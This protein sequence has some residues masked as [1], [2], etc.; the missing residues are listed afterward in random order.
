MKKD[1]PLIAAYGLTPEQPP[2][3]EAEAIGEVK[4]D[5]PAWVNLYADHP[6]TNSW[7]HQ[8]VNYL[9]PLIIL[10]LLADETRPRCE[11]LENGVMLI[12]RGVNLS[13]GADPEDMVSVRL[14]VD[15]H[16]II[17]LHKR[18]LMALARIDSSYQSHKGP[19][20]P[21]DF[22][23][24][25]IGN[26][27]DVMEPVLS[28]IDEVID[29]LEDELMEKPRSSLRH[30]LAHTRRRAL[31]LK[32]YISPQ[33]DAISKLRNADLPWLSAQNRMQLQEQ[34]DK[35][36]RFIE[37]LDTMRERC[38]IIQDELATIMADKLNSNTYILT[39]VAAIF[40]PLGFL[41]GLLG[42][43]VGGMPGVDDSNAFLIVCL[44]CFGLML[45]E[46]LLFRKLRW[47]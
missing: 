46:I 11:I 27:L 45:G 2:L 14:W 36:T 6:D 32:R 19:S 15:P 26:L 47:L 37:H 41:T 44:A 21:A 29:N 1:H 12:L 38:Q 3:S 20:T 43:N 34:Y 10:A 17:T 22:I 7:L 35:I 30:D 23:T 18:P 40:L 33:R 25:L 13:E 31:M 28:E 8:H 39:V 16:R 5:R 42:I 4:S 24:S 9:D